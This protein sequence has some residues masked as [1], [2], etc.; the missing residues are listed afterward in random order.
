MFVLDRFGPLRR[1]RVFTRAHARTG[2][3]M[4]VAVEC[5]QVGIDDCQWVCSR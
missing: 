1:H 4:F 2:V 3:S 5:E